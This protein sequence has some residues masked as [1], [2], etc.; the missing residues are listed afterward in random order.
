MG[1][2]LLTFSG[3]VGTH[4]GGDARYA[5]QCRSG[6]PTQS[7]MA[8]I[9]CRVQVRRHHWTTL[10]NRTGSLTKSIGV[11]PLGADGRPAT[12]TERTLPRWATGLTVGTVPLPPETKEQADRSESSLTFCDSLQFP[13]Q[14]I[15]DAICQSPVVLLRCSTKKTHPNRPS[16]LFFCKSHTFFYYSDV[17]IFACKAIR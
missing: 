13:T 15:R 10:R 6:L 12:C 3:Y 16:F 4:I 9:G 8:E 7:S 17:C 14:I 1:G 5:S 11:K 2:S